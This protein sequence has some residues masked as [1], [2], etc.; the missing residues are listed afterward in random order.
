MSRELGGGRVK[1]KYWEKFNV[2]MDIYTIAKRET[3]IFYQS[4]VRR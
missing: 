3:A 4:F 1:I 2:T